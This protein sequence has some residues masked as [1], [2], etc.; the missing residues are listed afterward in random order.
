M[1]DPA[2]TLGPLHDHLGAVLAL[3]DAV[4]AAGGSP[5]VDEAERVR[6]D[7]Y[8]AD[9][10]APAGWAPVALLAGGTSERPRGEV[11][12]YVAVQADAAGGDATGDVALGPS[13][14]REAALAAAV[15]HVRTVTSTPVQ[16]WMRNVGDADHRRAAD[17]GLTVRRRLAVL[18]RDLA[19]LPAVPDPAAGVRVRAATG[20]DDDDAIVAVLAAAHAGTDDAGWDVATFRQRTDLDW[21]DHAD[22]LLAVDDADRAL[23]VHWLKRRSTTVGEVHNLA[24]HPDGQGRG[25]GRLL[26]HAGLHH[27]RDGGCTEVLLWVDRANERAVS[28]YTSQGFVT[29]WEDVAFTLSPPPAAR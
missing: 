10:H 20:P 2:V 11:V 14:P 29:R 15:D 4:E 27:L 1:P 26:L 12:G 17:A 21:F 19:D 25:L 24:I 18:G 28:L 13:A 5:P 9:G 3:L 8:A 22:V 23:G 7:A 16:L 6:L